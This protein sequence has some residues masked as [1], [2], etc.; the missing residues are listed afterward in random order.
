MQTLE[1]NNSS[2]TQLTIAQQPNDSN[3][4]EATAGLQSHTDN[5]ASTIDNSS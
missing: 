3:S 1:V 5:S 2:S 4:Q